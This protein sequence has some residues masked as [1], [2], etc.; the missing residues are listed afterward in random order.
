MVI[1]YAVRIAVSMRFAWN[2]DKNNAPLEKA[3]G[4]AE[5]RGGLHGCY[6]ASHAPDNDGFL[7][8]GLVVGIGWVAAL[9]P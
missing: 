2:V 5:S 7:F 6:T 8:G 4:A 9:E 3:H 1:T